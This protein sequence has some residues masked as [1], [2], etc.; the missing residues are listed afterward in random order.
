MPAS[1]RLQ[2]ADDRARHAV[3]LIELEGEL[4]PPGLVMR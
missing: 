3:K 1:S 2:D 4:P